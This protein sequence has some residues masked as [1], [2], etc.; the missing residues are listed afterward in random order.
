MAALYAFK[1]NPRESW[2]LINQLYECDAV[3]NTYIGTYTNYLDK[4]LRDNMLDVENIS[5]VFIGSR[6]LFKETFIDNVEP[7]SIMFGLH[8]DNG[9]S[10]ADISI[11]RTQFIGNIRELRRVFREHFNLRFDFANIEPRIFYGHA[12]PNIPIQLQYSN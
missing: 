12:L 2:A 4:F 1:L 3:P 5:T 11:L 9:A 10:L 8:I 7:F 6:P